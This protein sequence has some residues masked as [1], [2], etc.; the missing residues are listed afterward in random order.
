MS[1]LAARRA[2]TGIRCEWRNNSV[3]SAQFTQYSN[4]MK[5]ALHELNR[6]PWNTATVAHNS[7]KGDQADSFRHGGSTLFPEERE[8]LGD[9]ADATGV[10]IADDAIGFARQ[11]PAD[12]GQPARF[13]RAD[14]LDRMPVAAARG[15]RFERVSTSYGAICW[16][17]G[18]NARARGIAVHRAAA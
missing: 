3:Y 13:E 15:E 12:A 8:L 14:V 11:L 16:L 5:K 6:L 1:Q 9:G 7:H 2:N 4:S 18:Q 10:D 17:P